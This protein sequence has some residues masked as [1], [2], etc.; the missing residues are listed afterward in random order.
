[1]AEEPCVLDLRAC[2]L[3]KSRAYMR[4][5]GCLNINCADY[6]MKK[7]PKRDQQ[8]PWTRGDPSRGRVWSWS[9]WQKSSVCDKALS[10]TLAASLVEVKQ[11]LQ[12]SESSEEEEA[13]GSGG[14]PVVL[15]PRVNTPPQEEEP[16]T[17]EPSPQPKKKA[18][19]IVKRMPKKRDLEGG[20]GTEA[21]GSPMDVASECAEEG[22]SAA[23]PVRVDMDEAAATVSLEEA[24]KVEMDQPDFSDGQAQETPHAEQDKDE[25]AVEIV[26]EN[27]VAESAGA[28]GKKRKKNNKGQKRKAWLEQRI[29]MLREE[30]RWVGEEPSAAAKR[31]RL[32]QET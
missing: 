3:C 7:G 23:P 20:E 9:E 6:Y 15:V 32:Q 28:S 27:I 18:K 17:R 25:E 14:V 11:E 16:E 1:M 31:Q 8:G 26:A 2:R 5:T 4:K 19:A 24:E 13:Q 12:D 10:S 29:A 22:G 21:P 30:G